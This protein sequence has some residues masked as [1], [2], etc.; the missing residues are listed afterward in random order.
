MVHETLLV[1]NMILGLLGLLG[2]DQVGELV[3]GVCSHLC[4]STK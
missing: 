3:V 2:V 4:Y 1:S